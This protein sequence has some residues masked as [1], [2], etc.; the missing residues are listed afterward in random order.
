MSTS[1]VSFQS[2]NLIRVSVLS[3]KMW[4]LH[5]L[6]FLLFSFPAISMAGCTQ[7]DPPQCTVKNSVYGFFPNLGANVFFTV[8]F[9]ILAIVQIVEFLRWKTWS[10]GIVVTIGCLLE[11]IGTLVI[12]DLNES[13]ALQELSHRLLTHG[14]C[15]LGYIG[16]CLM[17]HNPFGVPF[18]IQVSLIIVAPSFL[19]AALYLTLK[20]VVMLVDPKKSRLKPHLYTWIFVSADILSFLLQVGGGAIASSAS[21]SGDPNR[22]TIGNDI[23]MAG[24][25]WQVI[26][27]SIFFLL[28]A[29]FFRRAVFAQ[30]ETSSPQRSDVSDGR[31]FQLFIYGMVAAFFAIYI[32]CVYRYCRRQNPL[33]HP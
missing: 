16:R 30:K 14:S 24:I 28:A 4:F 29:D 23:M 8:A 25:I 3:S 32:R 9:G 21:S 22:S 26:T 18:D 27:L 7:L 33:S 2:L 15:S 19:S 20:H 31:N 10:F 13:R 17:H 5:T 12:P 1:H 6:L 11:M